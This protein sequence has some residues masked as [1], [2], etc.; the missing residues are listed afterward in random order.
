MSKPAKLH[1]VQLVVQCAILLAAG[2]LISCAGCR[3]D[4][5]VN[6]QLYTHVPANRNPLQLDIQAQVTGPL[7][8]LHFK[9][10]SV[11]GECAPQKS[12]SPT[13]SF[14]FAENVAHDRVSLE[15][16]RDNECVARTS[17]DVA[18]DPNLARHQVEQMVG[19]QIRI[20]N[21]PPYDAYG[22]SA[23]HADIAGTVSG[24]YMPDYKVVTYTRVANTWYIQPEANS[25]HD[26]TDQGTWTT[27]THTGSSYAALLVKPGYEPFPRLQLL[28]PINGDVVAQS[29]V[30]GKKVVAPAA[31]TV[32]DE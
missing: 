14:T 7:D 29:V 1:P 11:S 12:D 25:M 31:A 20:T 17:V 28:P 16:W 19:V 9:W 30:K 24:A 6:V 15:V 21:V 4:Q 8:G 32:E 22:G 2:L 5:A 27:W 10:F 23:T 3:D 18:V 13:T 26:L